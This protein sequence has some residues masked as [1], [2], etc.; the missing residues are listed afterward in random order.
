MTTK[1]R[2]VFIL[3][4]GA[5]GTTYAYALMHTG[6]AGE[7]VL[8]DIDKERVKGEVMDLSH[9]L[10]FVPP[11]EIRSGDYEDCADADIIVITAGAKQK[12][13]ESRLELVKRN[14]DIIKDISG[15]IKDNTDETVVV[16]VT[17]PVDILTYVAI[18]ELNWQRGMVMG[19]GTVLD[20]SRF[21]YMLSEHCDI[22]ARNVHAYILGEHGDSE[23]AAWSMAHIAGVAMNEYCPRCGKCDSKEERAKIVE[24]VR[25]SAY[26]IID[27]KGSTFYAIGLSLVRITGAVLR[28]EN[29]V[30]TVSTLL[31]GEYGLDDICLSVPCVLGKDGINDILH[32][33]LPENEQK[34]LQNSA[35]SLKNILNQTVFA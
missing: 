31:Q 10:P 26:H 33:D 12:P 19:S 27:Y 35:D 29:S 4:A 14:T 1:N 16:M 6:L 17:N 24:A 7:I 32:S 25:D 3:G 23:I 34:G 8:A 13:G 28:N 2:K 22:D 18:K 21:R 15:K 5:V 30:L 9:G 20:T 11:V